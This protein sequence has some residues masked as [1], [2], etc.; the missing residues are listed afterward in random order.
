MNKR[1]LIAATAAAVFAAGV[2]AVAAADSAPVKCNGANS[3]KGTSACASANS[4]CK[5]M[6]SCKGQGWT[7]VKTPEEC[8][9]KGG[10]VQ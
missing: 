6:N 4:S 3:C 10:K 1:A 9:S 7:E 5:G 8:A 2:P